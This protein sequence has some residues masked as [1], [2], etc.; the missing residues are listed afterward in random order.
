MILMDWSSNEQL[1]HVGFL[2]VFLSNNFTF[3]YII[4][5]VKTADVFL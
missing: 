3:K 1:F 5:T 2:I 4:E